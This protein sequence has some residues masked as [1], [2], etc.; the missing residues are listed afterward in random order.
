MS[1]PGAAAVEPQDVMLGLPGLVQCGKWW[2]GGDDPHSPLL[3]PIFGDFSGMPPIDVFQGTRDVLIA[4]ARM[5][6]EKVSAVGGAIR[7]FEYPGAFHVF[8][9]AT[10]TPEARDAFD[11]VVAALGVHHIA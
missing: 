4:D 5:L 11:H 6:C 1:N 9:A 7:L 8:V 10:F 3:S 2:A